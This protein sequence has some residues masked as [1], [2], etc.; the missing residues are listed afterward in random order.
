TSQDG[1]MFTSIKTVNN[2]IDINTKNALFDFKADFP[3][4]A[5]RYIRVTAKNNVCPPGHSGAGKPGWIFAD[6]IV[7]E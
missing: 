4:Q 2:P 6:E 1:K 7:V 3:A 5:V